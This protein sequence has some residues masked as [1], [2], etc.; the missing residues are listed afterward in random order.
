MPKDTTSTERKRAIAA[1]KKKIILLEG[2]FNEAGKRL[3]EK[4]TKLAELI[5]EIDE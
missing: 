4:R 2:V 5:A 3:M 1:I